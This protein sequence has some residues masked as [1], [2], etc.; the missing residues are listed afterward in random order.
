[1]YST[2]PR[3]LCFAQDFRITIHAEFAHLKNIQTFG[4]IELVDTHSLEEVNYL[5]IL[6][7]IFSKRDLLPI[8]QN[9]DV[10]LLVLSSG[11]W[12]QELDTLPAFVMLHNKV[13]ILINQY[14]SLYDPVNIECEI[15]KSFDLGCY[16][17][18]FQP[19]S[20]AFKKLLS[21]PTSDGCYYD[22]LVKSGLLQVLQE[23]FLPVASQILPDI[24]REIHNWIHDIIASLI[25]E[26]S[27]VVSTLPDNL[28]DLDP[29]H[30]VLSL[31]YGINEMLNTNSTEILSKYTTRFRK[32]FQEAIV[33]KVTSNLDT[34]CTRPVQLQQFALSLYDDVYTNIGKD[35]ANRLKEFVP[36]YCK[37][38]FYEDESFTTVKLQKCISKVNKETK[39]E[40]EPLDEPNFIINPSWDIPAIIDWE[41]FDVQQSE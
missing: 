7:L 26:C 30:E 41:R 28:S 4:N 27:A 25:T 17:V 21:E 11:N 36:M 12:K 22:E 15:D 37:Q 29:I 31:F 9:S 20:E 38:P 39:E 19:A 2:A 1:M 35:V 32:E 18:N 14:N 10:C 3:H 24:L 34:Y 8:V 33:S 13:C 16:F 23:V 6:L 5:F 40:F